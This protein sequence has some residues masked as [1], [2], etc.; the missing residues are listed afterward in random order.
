ML[1]FSCTL[2][3]RGG[4]VRVNRRLTGRDLGFLVPEGNQSETKQ[5]VRD[6]AIS[7]YL[8][9]SEAPVNMQTVIKWVLPP[10][11]CTSAQA[12]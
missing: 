8:C 7:G 10:G 2:F 11:E 5:S 4:L 9:M 12:V 6:Q 3:A 1:T